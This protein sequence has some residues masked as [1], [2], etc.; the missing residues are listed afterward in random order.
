MNKSILEKKF[1][2]AKN[3]KRSFSTY[4]KGSGVEEY[5]IGSGDWLYQANKT[6]DTYNICIKKPCTRYEYPSEE[7]ILIEE[8]FFRVI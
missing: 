8:Q 4:P 5:C 7:F 2:K 1:L 6:G 3:S